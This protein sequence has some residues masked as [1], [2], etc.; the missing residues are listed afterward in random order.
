MSLDEYF[1]L[2]LISDYSSAPELGELSWKWP[3]FGKR[4][5]VM[6]LRKIE[7]G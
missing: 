3:F 2:F 7:Q 6:G 1:F 5:L 4:Y